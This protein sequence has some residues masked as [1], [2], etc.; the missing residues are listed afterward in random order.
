MQALAPDE[1]LKKKAELKLNEAL[2]IPDFV[3]NIF[4]AEI[5]R[6]Y[7]ESN[8][9][10]QVKQDDVVKLIDEYI[11][12]NKT[13]WT[14]HNIFNDHWL[15]VEPVFEHAGWKVKFCKQPYYETASSFFIFSKEK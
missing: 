15:D 4:N 7:S 14:H 9:C 6:N 5:A 1:V 3:I 12:G 13:H 10:A 8:D 11:D 2:K